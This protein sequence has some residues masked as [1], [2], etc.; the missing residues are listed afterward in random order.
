M[1]KQFILTSCYFYFAFQMERNNTCIL[2]IDKTALITATSAAATITA[3]T[4]F[5]VTSTLTITSTVNIS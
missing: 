4:T 1:T 2:D 5:T 3:T